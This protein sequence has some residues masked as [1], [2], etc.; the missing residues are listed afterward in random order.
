[1]LST[2]GRPLTV[3]VYVSFTVTAR[4]M[5][6]SVTTLDQARN[7]DVTARHDAVLACSAMVGLS[8]LMRLNLR[9]FGENGVAIETEN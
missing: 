9:S 3:P 7:R 5:T 6:L 8:L 4:D 1:M 2:T